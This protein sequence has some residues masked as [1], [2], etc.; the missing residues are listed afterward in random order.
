MHKPYD[1]CLY[2]RNFSKFVKIGL[3]GVIL[4]HLGVAFAMSRKCDPYLAA[5]MVLGV[6]KWTN[7]LSQLRPIQKTWNFK[8]FSNPSH[9]NPA[10][11][12][13][14]VKTTGKVFGGFKLN[15]DSIERIQ[16][17]LRVSPLFS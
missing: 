6:A 10:K 1:H 13:Y 2:L 4:L 15:S 3:S 17:A 8:N 14:I 16:V 9:H 5:N 7:Q 12:K 11:F